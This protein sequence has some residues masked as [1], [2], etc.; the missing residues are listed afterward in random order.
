MQKNDL[1]V[2]PSLTSTNQASPHRVAVL[3]HDGVGAFEVALAVQAFAAANDHARDVLYEVAVAGPERALV[4]RTGYATSFRLV[5]DRLLSWAE[6][7]HTLIVPAYPEQLRTP[8]ALIETVQRAHAGGTRV[9]SLCLGTFLVAAA[10][11]LDG[12]R[13]TTHWHWADRLAALHPMVRVQP[14]R[15]FV[16]D[17]GLFTSGGGTAAL[18]L[19]LHLI[20]QDHGSALAA[21]IARFMVVPLRRDGDQTQYAR[22][23]VTGRTR[24][25]QDTL[26][27]AEE[28]LDEASTVAALAEH[29][30]MST[31][32][33]TRRFRDVVG[34]S[35]MEW[36]QRAKVR[37]AQELLQRT[38]WTID[39]IAEAS[40]FGSEAA[41]RYHFTRLTEMPP[42]R[43]RRTFG[44]ARGRRPETAGVA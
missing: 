29:A 33:F 20:E 15:L 31:R 35:P 1:M 18:D 37:R 36:L 30:C 19:V 22:W 42:G 23:K 2:H 25:L 11:L 8:A 43:Y 9:V 3:S 7:A 32:T 10:G 14:E 27:W 40:G 28:H 39:R 38:A 6:S 13:A 34:I 16:E 21:E 24:S 12:L 17:G 41:L 26:R 5:P 4:T 44:A